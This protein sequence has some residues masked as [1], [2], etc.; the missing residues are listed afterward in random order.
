M[1]FQDLVAARLDDR[2][3]NNNCFHDGTRAMSYFQFHL[4]RTDVSWQ[5]GSVSA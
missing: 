5:S 3:L 4:A 2:I 1:N